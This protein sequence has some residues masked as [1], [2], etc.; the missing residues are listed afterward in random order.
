[1]L[2]S[3][4][5]SPFLCTTPLALAPNLSGRTS[6]SIEKK[7]SC[8]QALAQQDQREGTAPQPAGSPLER[9]RL[10]GILA[11]RIPILHKV[12]ERSCATMSVPPSDATH[13]HAPMMGCRRRDRGGQYSEAAM[14]CSLP[15]IGTS[16]TVAPSRVSCDRQPRKRLAAGGGASSRWHEH[17]ERHGTVG[18]DFGHRGWSKR[19]LPPAADNRS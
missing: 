10:P 3:P 2:A 4:R 18:E 8:V 13:S 16:I 11:E 5:S 9:R 17:R 6:Y 1:M 19:K 15:E 12:Q 7:P 14:G